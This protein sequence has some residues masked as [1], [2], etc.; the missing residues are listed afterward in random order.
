MTPAFNFSP[1]EVEAW[2]H[3]LTAIAPFATSAVS[4]A[5]GWWI[6]RRERL[7][8]ITQLEAQ[9]RKK[10]EDETAAVIDA[11][12]RRFQTLI[13]GYEARVKDLMT[14]IHS[15]RDEVV[16]LRQALVV[17]PITPSGTNQ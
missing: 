9:N 5:A 16:Q 4:G 1:A 8:K 10:V 14:E 7:A 11:I 17:T 3:W 6:G 12:T 2:S 13:N 15:L